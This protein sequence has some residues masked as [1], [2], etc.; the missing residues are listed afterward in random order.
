MRSRPGCPPVGG[1]GVKDVLVKVVRTAVGI[2]LLTL[3]A[4]VAAPA[5]HAQYPPTVGA[6]RVSRSELKQCQ[7]TQFSG[8]GFAPG[9]SVTV[10][11]EQPGGGERVVTTVTADDKGGFKVKVCFDQTAPEGEHTLVARGAGTDGGAHEDRA[12][13]TVQG[14]VCNGK[15][16]EVHPNVSGEDTSTENR[17]GGGTQAGSG[18]AGGGSGEGSGDGLGGVPLPRT[19][20]DVILPGLALGFCLVLAGA[21]TVHLTHRR[22]VVAG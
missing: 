5:A 6:G 22:R 11:D 13:V 15:N 18:G 8:E 12:T 9:T 19:G 10:V 16:D 17:G 3:G 14:S 2:L 21:A 4:F 7:C 1:V 20:A